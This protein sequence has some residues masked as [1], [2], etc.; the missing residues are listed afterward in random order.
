MLIGLSGR[1]GSGKDTA[2]EMLLD[3]MPEKHFHIKGFSYKLKQ[4]AEMFTGIPAATM[5]KQEVKNTFLPEWGMTLRQLLQKLGTDAVRD[6]LHQDAWVLALFAD[7]NYIPPMHTGAI[8]HP[9]WI[10]TDVRFPNEAQAI[11]ERGGII[12]RMQRRSGWNKAD[13]LHPSE[14][15]LDLY[16]FDH[17]IDNNGTLENLREEIQH[18]IT[19][20][21]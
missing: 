17:Y 5:S 1:I 7:Y 14:T 4:V 11:R 2:A 20:I 19:K 3:L 12:L 15:A 16:H 13:L 21:K 9:N 6:N 8:K 10:I 18:L